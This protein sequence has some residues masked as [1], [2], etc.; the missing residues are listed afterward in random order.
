MLTENQLMVQE[1]FPGQLPILLWTLW[2]LLITEEPLLIIGNDPMECSHAVLTLL[3]LIAPLTST[4]D[5]RP[6]ITVLNN[7]MLVYSE[8]VQ[9]K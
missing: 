2:E 3:S 6:Y 1:T 7:D 8:M 9:Q 4:A 5:I